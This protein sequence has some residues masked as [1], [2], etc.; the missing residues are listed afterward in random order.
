MSDGIKLLAQ[1]VFL[2]AIRD[3]YRGWLCKTNQCGCAGRKQADQLGH[4]GRIGEMVAVESWI[5][6]PNENF[7]FFAEAMG[8]RTG[9]MQELFK[10]KIKSIKRGEKLVEKED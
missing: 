1:N 2:L 7:K 10:D 3:F 5:K 6:N 8:K 9:V 4:A